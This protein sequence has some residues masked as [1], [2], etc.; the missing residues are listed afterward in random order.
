MEQAIGYIRVSTD[1]Q[2]FERQRDEIVRY[3][4]DKFT[5]V[6]IFEDKQSGSDYDT[7]VGFQ[8]LLI[9]LDEN[10]HI[11]VIIF[12]EIS[13]MGRDTVMQ[14]TTYKELTRKGVR[15]YT[16]GKGEFASNKEDGLLFTVLS[17][18]ADYEKQ[19]IIDR[20]SS[21]RRKVVRD[22]FT[23]ISN[24]PY[25]YNIIFTQK[26]DRQVLKRQFIKINDEEAKNIRKMFEIVDK[27]GTAFDVLRYLK[28]HH[29]K[30][31]RSKEWGKTSVLRILHST[32][33][34]GE[35]QFGKYVK[36]KKSKYS[37]SKRT[38]DQIIV[39][40]VPAILSKDLFDRV[41]ERLEN[42][43]IKF[44]PRNQKI[45]F[46][47]KGLLQCACGGTMQTVV[48]TRS[49]ERLYRCPQRNIDGVSIKSCPIKSIKADYLES[50]LLGEFK[51]KIEH[52]N[53]FKDLRIKK[54]GMLME[55]VK[56]L[57]MRKDEIKRDQ[58]KNYELLKGYY[59]K[60]VG[61]QNENPVQASALDELAENMA[62]KMSNQ[63]I[64][65]ETL[66]KKIIETREKSVDYSHFKDIQQ[67]LS[68]ITDKDVESFD[69]GV[70]TK[71]E[72]ARSYIRGI[73]LAYREKETE[74]FRKQIMTLR[75]GL[76]RKNN[77]EAK[78]LYHTVANKEHKLRNTATQAIGFMVQFVNNYYQDM[79]TLYYHE[80]PAIVSNY[81][82]GRLYT[83]I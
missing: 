81:H 76:Y 42:N 79:W 66:E 17:A 65:L 36:N 24:R 45:L 21:G 22:G 25:G 14:V 13:R 70:D 58:K 32:T 41:Q 51:K 39:V 28:A 78:E 49:S 26:K 5:V 68:F 77:K 40:K 38:K 47:F 71:I 46:V 15:V 60:S 9:Y 64:E 82:R 34:Y 19:T 74:V 23:Q 80:N 4:K 59:E 33:Y 48:E 37:L 20:T 1:Q 2:D 35:W 69:S 54:L 43:R 53:F 57:E 83:A 55:P 62:K 6:K 18:I 50:M 11:K 63:K 44:N 75:K 29:V 8:D 73:R 12:D 72:F 52:V 27:N 10:P 3:A 16:R 30:P 31:L 67:A 56:I 61:M 7:R